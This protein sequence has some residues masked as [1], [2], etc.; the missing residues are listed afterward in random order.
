[1][2]DRVR[3]TMIGGML[4]AAIAGA[5]V[6]PAVIAATAEVPVNPVATVIDDLFAPTVNAKDFTRYA[7]TFDDTVSSD[8]QRSRA[9]TKIGYGHKSTVTVVTTPSGTYSSDAIVSPH[10]R[11]PGIEVEQLS[12]VPPVD[13]SNGY[14][15][16]VTQGSLTWLV[17]VP[18]TPTPA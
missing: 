9:I 4:G 18:G 13:P 12:L 17:F 15:S 14:W 16:S 1:M 7:I 6:T 2:L 5:L 11:Y 3:I 10:V 8:V